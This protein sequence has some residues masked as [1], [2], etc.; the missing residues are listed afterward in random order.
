MYQV[1]PRHIRDKIFA[2]ADF[3]VMIRLKTISFD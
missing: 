1:A 2:V 3:N